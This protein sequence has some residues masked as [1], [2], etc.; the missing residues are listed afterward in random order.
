MT[1]FCR[2]P[3]TAFVVLATCWL[4]AC[5]L[6]P[7][8]TRPDPPSHFTVG[9]L[10]V[11][12]KGDHG[13]PLILIP[14]LGSG[15]WAWQGS[16]DRLAPEHRLYVLTLAG[17]DGTP[18]PEDMTGLMDQAL[19]SLLQ[20]VRQR[21]I[22]QPVL[23]GHSMGGTLALAFAQQHSQLI[24]GVIAADGLPIF[25]GFERLTPEQRRA[26][27]LIMQQTIAATTPA[28]FRQQQIGYMR[29]MG[30][31]G[32]QAALK[33]GE[34][35]ARSDPATVAQFMFEDLTTDIRADLD[36]ISVPVLVISPYN[37]P[38]FKA[39]AA[40]GRMPM[41]S[42]AQKTDHYRSLMQGTPDLQVVSISPARH[43]VMLD[44]PRAFHQAVAT[45]LDS[46]PDAR[47]ADSP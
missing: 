31:I 20:L 30:V 41:M 29:R 16:I 28:S 21:H 47:P 32:E 17:F 2:L 40:S 34:L 26:R 13:R 45:F 25:P 1:R 7:T 46:L 10:H 33:Y 24:S 18:P 23:I 22:E 37:A 12:V 38:D 4:S 8:G 27:A 19:A 36:Q 15:P 11:Q 5:T 3:C 44:Q 14:G 42:E 39:A 43:F 35:Q 6:A 9:T